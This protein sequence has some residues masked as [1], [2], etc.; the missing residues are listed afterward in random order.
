MARMTV[1]DPETSKGWAGRL[2]KKVGEAS[3]KIPN[4]FRAMGSSPWALDGYL[5]LNGNIAQGKIGGQLV[6]TVT[7]ATS[8]YNQCDYCVAAHTSM[9]EDAGLLTVEQSLNARKFKGLD[10]KATAALA[11]TKAVLETNGKVSDTELKAVRDAG[12]GDEEIVE[13]LTVMAMSTMANYL[14]NVSQVDVD[15]PDVPTVG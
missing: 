15:F 9:A 8:E 13:I 14:S 11:F 2:L 7:L 6:K 4:M 5:T 1:L 10:D 12:F 3:G